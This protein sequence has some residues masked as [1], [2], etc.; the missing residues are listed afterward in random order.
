[1]NFSTSTRTVIVRPVGGGEETP[2]DSTATEDTDPNPII[3]PVSTSTDST[4][5][6]AST[7]PEQ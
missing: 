3:E 5:E 6:T 2:P 4:E 7:T 1:M